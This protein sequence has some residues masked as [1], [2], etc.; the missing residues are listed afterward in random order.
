[1]KSA[2]ANGK[3]RFGL[4]TMML[5]MLVFGV[6]AAAA[7]YLLRATRAGVPTSAVFV[8]FT[9][10]APVLLVV[11]MSVFSGAMKWLDRHTRK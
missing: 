10:A 8:I 11:L 3:L 2:S 7:S 4:A 5:V 6:M 1:V 9:I